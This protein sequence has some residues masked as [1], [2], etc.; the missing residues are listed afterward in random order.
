MGID[1]VT[2]GACVVGA[3]DDGKLVEGAKVVGLEVTA[4]GRLVFV[5]LGGCVGCVVLGCIGSVFRLD[6][7]SLVPVGV[8]ASVSG[9]PVGK[10]VDGA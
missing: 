9:W 1:V 8:G 5:F 7:G 4:V 2:T 6:V 3:A 10:S